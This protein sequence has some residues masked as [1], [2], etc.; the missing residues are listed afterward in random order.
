MYEKIL[1]P[2]DGS[3]LAEAALPY[4]EL[5]SG[6]LGSEVTLIYVHEATEVSNQRMGQFYL[7]RTV[8]V[9]KQGAERGRPP[10]GG[11]GIKVKSA[12]QVGNPAEEIVGYAGKEKADL[13]LMA[14]HGQS[15]IRNWPLGNVAEKVVRSTNCP[16][17]LIRANGAH[18]ERVNISSVVLP[19]DGSKE[20]EAA[21]PYIEQLASKVGA[22]V[23]LLQVLA[24]SYVGLGYTY[25]AYTEQQI[26][27]D[28]ALA[29]AYLDKVSGRLRQSEI[30]TESVVRLGDAAGEIIDFTDKVGADLVAMSTHGRSGVG[31]WVF[32]SV[33]ERVLHF[34]NKPLLLVRAGKASTK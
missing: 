15:G 6:K 3:A 7:E 31:R 23:I 22:R 17:M 27:S 21:L 30:A 25:V 9:T 18:T 13:I 34:G 24:T 11:P 5:L 14:T 19:L 26:A 33:A 32:G 20:G 10:C 28:S 12:V 29:K 16:V 1:V 8:E 2:L 4:A